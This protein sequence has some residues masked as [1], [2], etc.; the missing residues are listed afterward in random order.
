MEIDIKV[1]K[2]DSEQEQRD[3]EIVVRMGSGGPIVGP[4]RFLTIDAPHQKFDV[5]EGQSI[6]VRLYKPAPLLDEEQNAAVPDPERPVVPSVQ[7]SSTVRKE[8][9]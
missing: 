8:K 2:W 7:P 1:K 5:E 9:P 6:E 4:Q 3:A